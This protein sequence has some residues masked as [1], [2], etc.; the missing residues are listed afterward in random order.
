M[1]TVNRFPELFDRLNDFGRQVDRVLV[2]WAHDAG[3]N[4]GL[5]AYPPVNVWEEA[6]VYHVEAELPGVVSEN[7]N[8]QVTAGNVVTIS[9]ERKEENL[10]GCW[11]RRERGA[12]KF[13]RALTF[14]TPLDP[15]KVEAKM[16]NGVLHLSLPK[17]EAAR[18]RRIT[19][20]AE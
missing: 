16:D 6:E 19:V 20:K 4:L 18:P 13:S 5:S 1:T 2:R 10:E 3:Q 7:L 11:H 14:P 9:G 8:I 12:G 15:D 17:A